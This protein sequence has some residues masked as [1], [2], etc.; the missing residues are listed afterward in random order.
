[1]VKMHILGQKNNVENWVDPLSHKKK[2]LKKQLFLFFL[3]SVCS[4]SENLEHSKQ[5]WKKSQTLFIFFKKCIF[6]KSSWC[7]DS[8]RAFFPCILSCF[9]HIFDVFFIFA[10]WFADEKNAMELNKIFMCEV[11]QRHIFY[12]F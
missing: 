3:E 10:V 12:L 9:H 1:M 5:S 8:V 7:R 2:T 6:F 4:R 11:S